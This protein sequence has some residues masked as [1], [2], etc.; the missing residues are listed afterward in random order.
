LL[1][2]AS[3]SKIFFETCPGAVGKLI[4]WSKAFGLAETILTRLCQQEP[5]AAQ[6]KAKILDAAS[7]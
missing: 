4:G 7:N 1:L 6:E 3:H 2:Q 5:L